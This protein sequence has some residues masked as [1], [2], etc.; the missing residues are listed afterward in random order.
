M[1]GYPR[2]GGLVG[3]VFDYV[4]VGHKCSRVR[5]NRN[6]FEQYAELNAARLSASGPRSSCVVTS[7]VEVSSKPHR[8]WFNKVPTGL[9]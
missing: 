9:F 1:S 4:V 2:H 6:P 7:I 5:S 3:E 8:D